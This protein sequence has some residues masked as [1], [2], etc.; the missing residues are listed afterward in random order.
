MYLRPS[1]HRYVT[2]APAGVTGHQSTCN[3]TFF[4]GGWQKIVAQIRGVFRKIIIYYPPEGRILARNHVFTPIFRLHTVTTGSGERLYGY[5]LRLYHLLIEMYPLVPFPPSGR[6]RVSEC[7][8]ATLL[9]TPL[10]P[11]E[12]YSISMRSRHPMAMRSD[13]R[14]RRS[15][16]GGSPARSGHVTATD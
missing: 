9:W 6:E 3:L 16:I 7:T 2:L 10:T 15:R 12:T 11:A 8:R 4:W 13:P 5:F 1:R 14:S